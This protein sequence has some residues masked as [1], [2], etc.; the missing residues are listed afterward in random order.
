[1][2]HRP[3]IVHVYKDVYP[4]VEGGIERIIYHLARLCSARYDVGVIVAG[5]SWQAQRYQLA[6]DVTV[7]VVPCAG[8]PLSTPLAPGFLTALRRSHADLFHFHTPHPTGE[9][10]YLLAGGQTPA[11]VTYHSDVVRQAGAMKLYAPFFE[12]FLRRMRVIMPTSRR[13]LETS[14]WLRRHRDRCEVVPLGYPLEDYTRTPPISERAAQLRALYGDYLLFLG[15]LRA[16]KGLDYLLEALRQTPEAHAVIAGEG[17]QGEA[18]R[19]QAQALG[20]GGRVHFTGRVNQIEALALLH[21]AAFFVLPAH[22]RSEAF[23]LCQIEAMACGLPVIS[24]NLPTGV[25]E[26]NA[27][28]VSGLVVPP[29]DP[30]ALASAIRRLLADS[31]LR[32]TLGEGGRRRAED[33]Y[34]ARLM[35]ERV[36]AVYHRA[37]R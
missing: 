28:G 7:E 18:L 3:R 30:A 36:C 32:R 6:P 37:L 34:T 14:P 21:G 12:R 35:A 9:L 33:L 5:R 24:T 26:V 20:L 29:A 15:C 31:E 27:D 10:A 8:R 16:Y 13:Y 17:A 22:Q 2:T 11:V 1:M 19:A 4:A 25:P 23:G